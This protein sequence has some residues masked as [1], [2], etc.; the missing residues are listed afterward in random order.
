MGEVKRYRVTVGG[1]ETV[2][3]LTDEDAKRYEDAELVDAE[4]KAA[5]PANKARTA[6]N[7][8]G[9]DAGPSSND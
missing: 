2:L 8:A 3:K 4:P 1:N 5:R 7:K 6:Q 9:K